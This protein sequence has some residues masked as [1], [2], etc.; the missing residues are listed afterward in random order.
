MLRCW[1]GL[2]KSHTLIHFQF[3]ENKV[4]RDNLSLCNQDPN[5]KMKTGFI[6]SKLVNKIIIKIYAEQYP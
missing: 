3:S 4:P 6:F 5:P 2:L 1:C